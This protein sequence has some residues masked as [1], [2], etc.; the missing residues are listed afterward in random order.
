MD[1]FCLIVAE[2]INFQASLDQYDRLW[3]CDPT[4]ILTASDFYYNLDHLMHFG[5]E[6]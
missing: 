2:K 6:D 1:L 5:L 3:D 4:T